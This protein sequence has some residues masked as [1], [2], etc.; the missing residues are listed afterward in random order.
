MDTPI[1]HDS[2]MNHTDVVKSYPTRD[3]T[4]PFTAGILVQVK[5]IMGSVRTVQLSTDDSDDS[6]G[7]VVT[8]LPMQLYPPGFAV[9]ARTRHIMDMQSLHYNINMQAPRMSLRSA[10]TTTFH[11][12]AA[13]DRFVSQRYFS[14]DGSPQSTRNFFTS[15][16]DAAMDDFSH[17]MPFRARRSQ[18]FT[19]QL[20]F[21]LYSDDMPGLAN[22]T[23]GAN[24]EFDDVPGLVNG[25][26]DIDGAN[27][28]FD[29]LPG[30]VSCSSDSDDASSELDDMPDLVPSGW[31]PRVERMFDESLSSCHGSRF[32]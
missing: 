25:I 18:Y 24:S 17:L 2:D 16:A 6:D 10:L 21:L 13:L 12:I 1:P 29:D 28:E 11:R 14:S 32:D 22:D 23:E 4:T 9:A 5:F 27:S 20:P 3:V 30:L 26:S 15:Y 8:S 19:S 31:R 7:D